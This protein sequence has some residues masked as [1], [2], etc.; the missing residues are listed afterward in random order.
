MKINK[1]IKE[2]N[3]TGLFQRWE[4][5]S[6]QTLENLLLDKLSD[7]LDE[8]GKKNKIKNLLQNLR[9]NGKISIAEGKRWTLK[10]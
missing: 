7:V 8:K 5:A 9:L 10:D 4:F 1:E 3:D 6:R 2:A